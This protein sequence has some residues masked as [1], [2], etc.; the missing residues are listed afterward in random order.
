MNTTAETLE[1]EQPPRGTVGE[2]TY[3]KIGEF[4]YKLPHLPR[5]GL[6][7]EHLYTV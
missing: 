2:L 6:E 3:L 7:K 4:P 1:T 5:G